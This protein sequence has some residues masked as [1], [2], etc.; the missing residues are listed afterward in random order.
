MIDK[1][2]I[3]SYLYYVL[4]ESVISDAEYDKLCRELLARWGVIKGKHKHLIKPEDLAAGTG[5]SITKYP[6]DII[7]AADKLLC[8]SKPVANTYRDWPT[9]EE[10]RES[11]QGMSD[12]FVLALHLDYRLSRNNMRGETTYH[13]ERMIKLLEE[14]IKCRNL[15]SR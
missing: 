1:Y 14:E 7:R 8:K 11:I 12:H 6:P 3:H 15:I 13:T 2:L 10:S 9:E 4:N 5:Y